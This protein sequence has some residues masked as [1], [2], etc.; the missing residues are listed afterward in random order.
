MYAYTT[1]YSSARLTCKTF[2][3]EHVVIGYN[4]RRASKLR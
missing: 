1:G 4:R 2:L 3:S